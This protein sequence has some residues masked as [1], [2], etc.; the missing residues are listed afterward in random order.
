MAKKTARI[1]LRLDPSVRDAIA[2]AARQDGESLS[3][4]V[5]EVLADWAKHR[6]LRPPKIIKGKPMDD[7]EYEAA[8]DA[9]ETLSPL[10]SI[11]ARLRFNQAP[12]AL[13]I[14]AENVLRLAVRALDD[15]GVLTEIAALNGLIEQWARTRRK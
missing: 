14:K 12:E 9:I 15:V 3:S 7:E 8:H 6:A 5:E 13:C 4:R 1:A 10:P 2:R 11:V